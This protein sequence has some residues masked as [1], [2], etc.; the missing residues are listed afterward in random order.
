[1]PARARSRRNALYVTA[2]VFW[3]FLAGIATA[4]GVAREIWLVP[5]IGQLRAHQSGTL[6][7]CMFF[8]GA[9]AAFVLRTRPSP[10]EALCIGA[11]WVLLGIA[12]EFGVGRYVDGLSWS[13]LLS[14]YDLSRGRLLSLVW[15]TVA[16]GPVALTRCWAPTGASAAD[17]F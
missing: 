16:L 15:V 11:C 13:R 4:A 14:D 8:L 6:L 3:F 7:V 9:I 1:M 2:A 17:A 5:H 10:R 12:F